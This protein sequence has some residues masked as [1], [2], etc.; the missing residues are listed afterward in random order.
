[1]M[2]TFTLLC[3]GIWGMV[4]SSVAQQKEEVVLVFPPGHD[5][6]WEGFK[7]LTGWREQ[8]DT[9]AAIRY[10]RASVDTGFPTAMYMLG[11]L[12]LKGKGVPRSNPEALRLFEGAAK[13]N[14]APACYMLGHIY[15]DGLIVPQ[16][17]GSAF[18]YFRRG[19]SLQ[20][21][22]SMDMVAYMYYKGLGVSQDYD[23]A[24]HYY[25]ILAATKGKQQAH[26]QY[27]TG[28]CYRNGY[29]TP[30]NLDSARYWLQ[31]A[32]KQNYWP[33]AHELVAEPTPENRSSQEPEL[34]KRFEE[35]R[36]YKEAFRAAAAN[37]ISGT[38]QGYAVYLDFSGEHI[39]KI[40]ALSLALGRKGNG[41]EGLWKEKGQEGELAAP[42]RVRFR[43]N[44]LL[45]DSSSR[46]TRRDRYSFG[47][48]EEYIF[49]SASLTVQF[50]DDSIRFS[51][52]MR[53]YSLL[54][55]EPG[56]PMFISLGKKS[57]GDSIVTVPVKPSAA[58]R[59][60]P[61]PAKSYVNAAFTLS[62][63]ARVNLRILDMQGRV[64][65]SRA[66]SQLPAGSYTYGFDVQ[67]LPAGMYVLQLTDG[68]QY[69]ESKQFVKP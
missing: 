14:Y 47:I 28:I 43:N 51:G 66:S 49:D 27:F 7:R 61:N 29:G 16:D 58:L 8:K 59:V 21:L 38:Y 56:Q 60:Y 9:V 6:W 13:K 39:Q 57:S 3:L 36:Q 37:D 54:R 53:F 55:R 34:K 67:Q 42:V 5:S 69:S 62:H 46:Y 45:F 31:L 20:S 23:S 40:V 10:L 22:E 50:M 26:S 24:F 48:P 44:T 68:R 12:Y 63:V 11:E 2:K 65:V 18:G 30:L 41:Y 25:R 52:D 15:R 33:A 19:A 17:F 32:A 64:L 4:T 35:L 1:M